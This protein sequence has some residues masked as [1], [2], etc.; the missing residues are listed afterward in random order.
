M[1]MWQRQFL[2]DYVPRLEKVYSGV[3]FSDKANVPSLCN[4]D[5]FSS[6]IDNYQSLFKRYYDIDMI[7]KK[8]NYIRAYSASIL[9]TSENLQKRL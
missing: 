8:K 1:G 9:I 6:L 2:C 7:K 4:V 5:G 3:L